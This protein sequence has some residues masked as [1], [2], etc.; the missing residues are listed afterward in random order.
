MWMMPLHLHVNQK[1]DYDTITC[2]FENI[3]GHSGSDQPCASIA[4]IM[5]KEFTLKL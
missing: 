2:M 3:D 5:L 4:C 1:S